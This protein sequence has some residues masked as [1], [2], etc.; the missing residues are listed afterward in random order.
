MD[1]DDHLFYKYDNVDNVE[2][3]CANEKSHSKIIDGKID[4]LDIT[5]P[6]FVK[7]ISMFF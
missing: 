4:F 6:K 1:E 2:I 5:Q 3:Y 7:V